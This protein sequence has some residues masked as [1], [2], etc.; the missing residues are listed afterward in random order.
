[1]TSATTVSSIMSSST[2]YTGTDIASTVSPRALDTDPTASQATLTTWFMASGSV[3][4]ISLCGLVPIVCMPKLQKS[5]YQVNI[6]QFLIGLAI[7]TL[8]ADALLHLLP[9]VSII[10]SNLP[11]TSHIL[12]LS[13]NTFSTY[14]HSIISPLMVYQMTTIS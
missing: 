8:T 6:L 5:Q 1:M 11:L 9:H 12:E 7:G 3:L 10:T 4:I 13:F 2:N 14:I